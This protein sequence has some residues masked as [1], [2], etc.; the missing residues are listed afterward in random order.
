MHMLSFFFFF[1]YP[2]RCPT[3]SDELVHFYKLNNWTSAVQSCE[4]FLLDPNLDY[5]LSVD[6]KAMKFSICRLLVWTQWH[7]GRGK[8]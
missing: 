8:I 6:D 2:A 4:T 7:P 1:Y 5:S 3:D